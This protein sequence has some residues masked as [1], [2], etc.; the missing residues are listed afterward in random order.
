MEMASA[1]E[2]C[3]R[4][5]PAVGHFL[6][7]V[8]VAA[9]SGSA[10]P[11][12]ATDILS[13]GTTV[14]AGDTGVLQADLD[15]ATFPFGVRLLRNAT[16]DLNGHSIAGGDGTEATV[17]GVGAEDG[18]GRGRFIIRGP[19]EIS[20]TGRLPVSV[21]GTFACVQVSDGR[22]QIT[23]AAGTVDIHDCVYGVLGSAGEDPNGR[24]R[25]TMDHVRLHDN[26]LDGAA[27]GRLEASDVD[28]SD[29]N[30]QGMGAVATVR[31]RNVVANNN[32]NGHGVFSAK[33]LRGENVTANGNVT[34]VG[35]WGRLVLVNGHA[36]GNAYFGVAGGAVAL[37]DSTIVDNGLAD[38][39]SG[40]RPRVVNTI[41]GTSVDFNMSSWGV[42]N[43]SPS[44]A[45]LDD[46]AGL[47]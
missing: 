5:R 37:K 10:A 33:R 8:V 2:A 35:S 47:F 7:L 6:L 14:A 3:G 42:C 31:V 22:A 1:P 16:L 20:G 45:F 4:T 34:G 11:A 28:A 39:L 19:G 27:V 24:A 40:R 26:A 25:V 36:S 18:S 41:C 32:A 12:A 23:G 44:G 46:G 13:C 15:C 30:G 9:L 38:I 29:N 21:G 43:G 17:L